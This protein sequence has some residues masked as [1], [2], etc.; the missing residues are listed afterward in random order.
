MVRT[1]ETDDASAERRPRKRKK[2]AGQA[3]LWI[4][5]GV[6]GGVLVILL[7]AA[8]V[9]III[10]TRAGE[11]QVRAPRQI[12]KAAP[13]P[14]PVQPVVQPPAKDIGE[15]KR[16]ATNIRLRAERPQRLNEL[17]QIKIFYM[18]FGGGTRPPPSAEDFAK[19]IGRDAPAI[20]QAIDEK[21]Y[22]IVPNVRSGI[23]AYERDPDTNSRH[24]FIDTMGGA[25]EISTQELLQQL[26]AQGGQ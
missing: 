18:D 23:I 22:V 5:L 7:I 1:R 4:G 15:K 24:A 13:A 2:P 20:K 6:G 10:A 12:D 3:G 14:A 8:I 11:P 9:G 16:Y 17:A 21:Y 26:K 25:R 19:S